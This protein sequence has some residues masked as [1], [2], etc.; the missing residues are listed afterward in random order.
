MEKKIN[1]SQKDVLTNDEFDK[2][3]VK[4]RITIWIPEMVVD[5]FR[6]RALEE[7]TKYQT[8]INK[9]LKEFISK[10]SL[11]KRVEELEKKTG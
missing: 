8:L 3:K 10:P 11:T 5:A 9:A 4:E 2:K 7:D 1:Y 6:Q